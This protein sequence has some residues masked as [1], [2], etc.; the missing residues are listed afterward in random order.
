MNVCKLECTFKFFS[1]T[2]IYVTSINCDD[3]VDKD[4][5]MKRFIRDHKITTDKMKTNLKLIKCEKKN[6]IGL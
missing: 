4:L 2:I 5:I 3:E 1:S 6:K